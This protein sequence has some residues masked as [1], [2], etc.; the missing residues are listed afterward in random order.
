MRGSRLPCSRA[1]ARRPLNWCASTWTT[2][3][4]SS[5]TAT[6]PR[7]AQDGLLPLA[8]QLRL[9]QRRRDVAEGQGALVELPQREAR[10]QARPAALANPQDLQHAEQIGREVGRRLRV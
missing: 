10:A 2:A 5:S 6:A 9:D 3:G 8:G 1:A 4:S 7:A